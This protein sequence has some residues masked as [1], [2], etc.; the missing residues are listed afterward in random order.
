MALLS[1]FGMK[2]ADKTIIAPNTKMNGPNP[3]FVVRANIHPIPIIS[4]NVPEIQANLRLTKPK[5][6]II[7]EIGE[8]A[9]VRN[10]NNVV[11][12]ELET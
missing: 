7:N 9:M 3:A 1:L 5:A 10:P 6:P 11:I 4:A 2:R 8:P 12:A